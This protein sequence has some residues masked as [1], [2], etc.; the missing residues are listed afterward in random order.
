MDVPLKT[1]RPLRRLLDGLAVR[2]PLETLGLSSARLQRVSEMSV[3]IHRFR[4]DR[5]TVSTNLINR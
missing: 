5:F 1:S 4:P 3:I 2:C